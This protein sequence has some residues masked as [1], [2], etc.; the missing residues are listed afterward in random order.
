MPATGVTPPLR[1]GDRPAA[2]VSGAGD[3]SPSSF[4]ALPVQARPPLPAVHR[5]GRQVHRWRCSSA[6]CCFSPPNASGFV[7]SRP[8]LL[9]PPRAPRP[10][11]QR[12][13]PSGPSRSASRESR[14]SDEAADRAIQLTRN[15][16][17]LAVRRG[18]NL[19]A[20]A[21]F[22][23]FASFAS[24]SGR[25]VRAHVGGPRSRRRRPPTASSSMRSRAPATRTRPASGRGSKRR[26]KAVSASSLLHARCPRRDLRVAFEDARNAA[27]TA[28]SAGIAESARRRW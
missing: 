19:H 17:R 25:Q 27:A 28:A 15:G 14:T 1:R 18:P 9:A 6:C 3:R 10:P 5:A 24:Q 22:S 7:N 21:D 20:D 11:R 4:A 2:A 26:I 8:S 12:R 23:K 13:F 16:F